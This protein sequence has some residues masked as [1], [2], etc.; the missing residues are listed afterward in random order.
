M[1][2]IMICIMVQY[3]AVNIFLKINPQC[4]H[5]QKKTSS[6]H[7]KKKWWKIKKA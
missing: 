6:E 7:K 2:D 4:Y 1:Y 5:N 3:D